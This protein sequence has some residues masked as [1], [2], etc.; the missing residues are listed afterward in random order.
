MVPH[1]PIKGKAQAKRKVK[2]RGGEWR[3]GKNIDFYHVL[4]VNI[5]IVL[6]RFS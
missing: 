3:E 5:F 4:W 6:G 1:L 2:E